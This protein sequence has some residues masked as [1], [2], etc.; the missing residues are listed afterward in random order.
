MK[1]IETYAEQMGFTVVGSS[2]CDWALPE[3]RPSRRRLF[4]KRQVRAF[5]VLLVDS[6]A[7]TGRDTAKTMNFI[8]T[9]SGC[10]IN[11]YSPEEGEIKLS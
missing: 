4:W 6:V 1:R 10:G 7:L 8:Q 9:I 11:I 5:R 2:Q 3:L